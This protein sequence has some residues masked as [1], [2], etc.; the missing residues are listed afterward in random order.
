MKT[1]SLIAAAYL[2]D[3]MDQCSYRTQGRMSES[4]ETTRIVR[5]ASSLASLFPSAF[6]C[7]LFSAFSVVQSCVEAFSLSCMVPVPESYLCADI[8]EVSNSSLC[9]FNCQ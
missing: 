9:P 2:K 3:A 7:L 5:L 6:H 4:I 8:V 1:F